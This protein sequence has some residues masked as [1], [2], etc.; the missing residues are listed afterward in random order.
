MLSD[1][2]EWA[3]LVNEINQGANLTAWEADFIDDMLKM[4]E[5]NK[6]FSPKQGEVIENIYK[7]R[8]G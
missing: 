1:Q 3:S 6:P 8:I 2:E 5:Q 7:K 4:I